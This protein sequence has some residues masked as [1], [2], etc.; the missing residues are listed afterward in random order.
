M[1]KQRLFPLGLLCKVII[2][3]V[4][5]VV[6]VASNVQAQMFATDTEFSD[7]FKTTTEERIE[8]NTK[9][10]TPNSNNVLIKPINKQLSKQDIVDNNSADTTEKIYLYMKNF[11]I[12]RNLNGRISCSMRFFIRA[13]TNEK[14]TSIAYRLKWPEMET[15]LN[16]DNVAINVPT[17]Y[18]Y[19]LLGKGCYEMAEAPNIIVNRCRIKGKTSEQCSSLIEW[20]Q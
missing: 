18:D 17:Y 2:Y 12:Q 15:P 9:K 8:T 19:T 13:E 16:F 6:F 4:I 10:L 5:A 1:K 20:V 7:D 3:S 14:I 11:K